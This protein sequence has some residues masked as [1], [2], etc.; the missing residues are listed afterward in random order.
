MD[1][2]CV[3]THQRHIDLLRMCDP[4]D[5]HVPR[6]RGR[7]TLGASLSVAP[8]HLLTLVGFVRVLCDRHRGLSGGC[9]GATASHNLHLLKLR[10]MWW[11]CTIL[12]F[13]RTVPD[14]LWLLA[15]QYISWQERQRSGE[16][17]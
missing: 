10:I 6:L 2:S 5:G 7:G 13:L 11:W 1:G 15:S 8:P 3:Y 17:L 9:N 14:Q 16:D 12:D 4:N